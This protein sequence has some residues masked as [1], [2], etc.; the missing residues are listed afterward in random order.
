MPPTGSLQAIADQLLQ[1][2]EAGRVTIRVDTADDFFPVVAEALAPGVR[3]FRDYSMAWVKHTT[4]PIYEVVSGER[5]M[6]I[7]ND[8]ETD[9][10]RPPKEIIEEYGVRAQMLTPIV[11]QDRLAAI[12]AVHDVRGPRNWTQENISACEVAAEQI[13][14]RLGETT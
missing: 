11:R 14:A 9:E 6:L 2:T 3:S 5:K 8:C 13:D 1:Q 7:Q 12:L 10:R 4:T